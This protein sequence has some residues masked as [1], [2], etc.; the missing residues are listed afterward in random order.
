VLLPSSRSQEPGAAFRSLGT[1][2]VN[3]RKGFESLSL[4]SPLISRL[5]GCQ[6]D[7]ASRYVPTL[8]DLWL[9][10]LDFL[11]PRSFAPKPT[12]SPVLEAMNG[13]QLPIGLRGEPLASEP[14]TVAMS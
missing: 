11:A 5:V 4:R 9:R 2:S 6:V 14:L 1:G 12:E 3:I 8:M 10:R 7:M 13:S